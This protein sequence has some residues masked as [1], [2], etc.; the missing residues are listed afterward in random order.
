MS[1]YIAVLISLLACALPSQGQE[2]ADHPEVR[3]FFWTLIQENRYGFSESEGAA[4]VVS[5]GDGSVD[6]VRWPSSEQHHRAV[7]RGAFPR[8]TIAIVHTHPNWIPEPS[9][10]DTRTA[11][12]KRVP[13][14]VVTRLHIQKTTGDDITTVARGDWRPGDQVA[15]AHIIRRP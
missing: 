4:F 1:R 9:S 10:V 12:R 8:G 3:S 11:K 5:R 7:W 15:M 6:F 2:I 14:Y 13:V